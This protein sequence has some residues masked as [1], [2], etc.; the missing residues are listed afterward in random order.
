[1]S[2]TADTSWLDDVTPQVA[3]T[4]LRGEGKRGKAMAKQPGKR[5]KS[6]DCDGQYVFF[7]RKIANPATVQRLM[8][9]LAKGELKYIA[10]SDDVEM[11]EVQTTSPFHRKEASQFGPMDLPTLQRFIIVSAC[12]YKWDDF[13]DGLAELAGR[14]KNAVYT[15]GKPAEEPFM[16]MLYQERLTHIFNMIRQRRGPDPAVIDREVASLRTKRGEHRSRSIM[17]PA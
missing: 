10:T 1:M 13:V 11:Y 16:R 9:Q 17:L 12:K 5:V 7:R 14:M 2:S 3:S 8:T 15:D 4:K 6:W